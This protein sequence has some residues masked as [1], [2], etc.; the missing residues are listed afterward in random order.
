MTVEVKGLN[1]LPL[2][3]NDRLYPKEINVIEK[4]D[5]KVNEIFLWMNINSLNQ[6]ILNDVTAIFCQV[7]EVE[8]EMLDYVPDLVEVREAIIKSPGYFERDLVNRLNPSLEIRRTEFERRNGSSEI[9][10][11]FRATHHDKKEDFQEEVDEYLNK[12]VKV[13]VP[14][15][16]VFHRQP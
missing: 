7:F 8:P 3:I 1:P 11:R 6:D 4:H 13:A 5:P 14:F 15:G 10:V 9:I 12:C 16:H 2:R